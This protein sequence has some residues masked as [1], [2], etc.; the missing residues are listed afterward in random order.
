M[1]SE[2]DARQCALSV[3]LESSPRGCR[4]PPKCKP[5]LWKLPSG[6]TMTSYIQEDWAKLRV[7]TEVQIL[8]DEHNPNYLLKPALY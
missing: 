1:V 4:L 7:D 8:E 6:A 3:R 5:G 2:E